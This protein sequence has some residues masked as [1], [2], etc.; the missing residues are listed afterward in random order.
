M[1][2]EQVERAV[3]NGPDGHE[4]QKEDDEGPGPHAVSDPVG[5]PLAECELVARA[6][7]GMSVPVRFPRHDR[8]P[9]VVERSRH[10]LD[11]G[12]RSKTRTLASQPTSVPDLPDW[13]D[14]E[15]RTVSVM[16]GNPSVDASRVVAKPPGGPWSGAKGLRSRG[17]SRRRRQSTCGAYR[18]R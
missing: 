18:G 13:R 6:D 16:N 12:A 2:A 3:G 17:A 5:S 14:P 9:L 15:P 4:D 8:S 11:W 7:S 10:H 1:G